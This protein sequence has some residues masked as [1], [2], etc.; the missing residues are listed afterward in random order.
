MLAKTKDDIEALREGGRRLA[1]H[2]RILSEMVKPG[3]IGSDLEKMAREMVEKDGD[4]LAFYGHKDRKTDKPYPSGLCLS[5]ND[6]IVHS[7]ASENHDVIKEGDVVS[8]D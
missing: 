7:P 2:L 6:V 8:L 3:V 4:L 5:I 1:R